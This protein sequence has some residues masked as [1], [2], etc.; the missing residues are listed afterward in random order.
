MLIKKYNYKYIYVYKQLCYEITEEH[1]N[2][3]HIY[4][5]ASKTEKTEKGTGIAI[6]ASNTQVTRKVNN[7]LAYTPLKC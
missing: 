1:D 4:T 3:K 2:Y 5:D 7:I 6:L